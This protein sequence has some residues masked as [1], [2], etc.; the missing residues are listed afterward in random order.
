[1]HQNL[2]YKFNLFIYKTTYVGGGIIKE[3]V[4]KI[5]QNRIIKNF[6]VL[7]FSDGIVSLVGILNMIMIINAI[8]TEQNGVITMVQTY[9]G[10]IS[11]LLTFSSFNGL[12]KYLPKYINS[13]DFEKINQY[14]SLSFIFEICAGII[15]FLMGQFLINS[16]ARVMDWDNSMVFLIRIYLISTIFN[17]IGVSSAIIRIFDKFIYISYINILVVFIRIIIYSFGFFLFKNT[18]YFLV[19]EILIDVVIKILYFYYMLKVLNSV[20]LK[21]IIKIRVKF[22]KE[23]FTFNLLSN[24]SSTIDIP[25]FY[26]ASFL[27][28]KY[29][30]FSEITVLKVVEKIGSILAKFANPLQQIIYPEISNYIAK[31]RVKESLSFSLKISIGIISVGLIFSLLIFS[32]YEF[33]LTIFLPDYTFSVVIVLLMY[34]AYLTLT[35]AAQFIHAYFLV[36]NLL[37]YNIYILIIV[38]IVY[39]YFLF[40][41]TKTYG[42]VGVM[43]ARILQA[44]AVI[45]IKFL[46]LKFGNFFKKKNNDYS[47]EEMKQ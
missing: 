24:I 17:I 36:F 26:L 42:L 25:V 41:L 18:M 10:L 35:H 6:S 33:W 3:Y 39:V 9:V 20:G 15:A 46:I 29:L 21:R 31:N 19:A 27:I 4:A 44:A 32:T 13:K 28:N 14:V 8:G 2:N 1:M 5:L 16:V 23:F 43:L 45:I 37:K 30:G 40:Q 22:D 7:I 11:S 38:N 12:I 47:L 34:I